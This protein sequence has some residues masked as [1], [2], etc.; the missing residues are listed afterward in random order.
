MKTIKRAVLYARVSS[1]DRG[2]EGRNLAGQL[3]MCREFAIEN[4]WQIVA[5]L[6]EDDRGASGASFELPELNHARDMAQKGEFDVLVV[7]EIDRLS[8]KLAKQLI[9]EEQLNRAGVE[10]VYVLAS[11]E[12]SPE[13][14]LNKHIRATIAEYE[15]EKIAER[16]VRGRRQVVKNGTIMLHGNKPPY[17]Y[18]LSEDR[19][20]LV[21]H[22]EEAAVVRLVY[23][24]YVEGDER[25]KRLS[26][27]AIANRLTEMKVSTWADIRGMF[28]KRGKGEWSWRL[29]MRI[30]DSE[31]YAGH[32]HYGK[33]NTFNGN[34]INAREWWLTFDVP[35]IV[36]EETWKRAQIQR[37]LNTSESLRHIKREYLLRSRVRCG[38]CKSS[39][40]CFATRPSGKELKYYL[41]YRCNG[42]MGYVANVEC[43]LPSFR[44]DIVDK[45]VWNWVKDLLTKPGVLEHGLVEYQEGREQFCAP[46][47]DR[48]IVLEDLWQG[49]KTQL[50]RVL[51]LYISGQVQRELLIDKKQQLE[52]TLSALEKERD[53]LNLNLE[54]EA[55]S[56]YE[57]Q[58]IVDFAAQIAEGLGPGD[59]SFEDRRRIIEL[60]DVRASFTVED[61]QKYVDVW[62]F[63]GRNKLSIENP[64]SRNAARAKSCRC[65]NARTRRRPHR[66]SRRAPWI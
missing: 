43:N 52:S 18:R 65:C 60:L 36:S 29:V 62:C 39:I 53:E 44:V 63:L 56:E 23:R 5:E 19:K 13:G 22:E 47:R 41:Y 48:L 32:W 1:D 8:R 28:K 38:L 59:E 40:N 3:E 50:D 34:K 2:K 46:I 25:G 17:G 64:T 16:M 7:R 9:V 31:T 57:I 49:S 54:S 37:K 66:T 6:A 21:I 33:R 26:A 10:V 14:R 58:Q 12:N 4:G 11:Y 55:L 27:R 42:Y 24:F 45:I 30:L 61:N 15:R 51:D 20:T 35:A